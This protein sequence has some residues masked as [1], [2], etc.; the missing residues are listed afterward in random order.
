MKN[1]EKKS[2]VPYT[3]AVLAVKF[4]SRLLVLLLL[5]PFCH[6]G[7][8]EGARGGGGDSEKPSPPAPPPTSATPQAPP[9]PAGWQHV[10]NFQGM[11]QQQVITNANNGVS[12]SFG[13]G[14]YEM[15]INEV[16]TGIQLTKDI[17]LSAQYPGTVIF[18]GGGQTGVLSILEGAHVNI[19]GIRIV[20]GNRAIGGCVALS[21][22]WLRMEDCEISGCEALLGGGGLFV[23]PAASN[24]QS[25]G[26]GQAEDTV[27]EAVLVGCNISQN[28]VAKG[29]GGGVL[30]RGQYSVLQM[31]SC[32]VASNSGMNGGGIATVHST[33]N[34]AG[35]MTLTSCTIATN[36]AG[37]GK[38]SEGFG[39]AVIVG[40]NLQ[41][42]DCDFLSNIGQ[43]AGGVYMYRCA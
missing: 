10:D 31:T 19:T 27:A 15:Y 42:T 28:S 2:R 1:F 3:M 22:G 38:R 11:D 21:E 34:E 24:S 20:N 7:R 13:P 37:G 30:M 17:Q 8:D 14:T 12:M 25:L 4:F 18:D 9:L 5:S 33:N 6:G 40:G 43:D 32:T 29:F 41:I 26:Q 35:T 39:G 36:V 23:G 16:W